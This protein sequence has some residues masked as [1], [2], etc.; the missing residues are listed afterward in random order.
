MDWMC[1]EQSGRI[2]DD[3]QVSGLNNEWIVMMM[4]QGRME[5]MGRRSQEYG[6]CTFKRK[7]KSI[8]DM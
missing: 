4:R 6:I 3:L 8:L 7:T 5:K 2:K 1:V